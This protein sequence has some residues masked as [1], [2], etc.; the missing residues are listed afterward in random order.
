MKKFQILCLS[1]V[2]LAA[3][4]SNKP[5]VVQTVALDTTV[6]YFDTIVH[7]PP[8][9]AYL[10]LPEITDTFFVSKDGVQVNLKKYNGVTDIN[11]KCPEDTITIHDTIM[12]VEADTIAHIDNCTPQELN[13]QKREGRRQGIK[14]GMGL[15]LV[16]IIALKLA[17]FVLKKKYPIITKFIPI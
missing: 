16:T 11:V 8:K 9:Y 5:I 17:V 2:L 13:K 10:S 12:H 1:L 3:C 6:V 7:I 15:L 14:I 4:S